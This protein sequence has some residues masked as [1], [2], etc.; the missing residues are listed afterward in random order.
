MEKYF[1]LYKIK[2]VLISWIDL[3]EEDTILPKGKL[4]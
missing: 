4:K 2:M 1:L 3:E